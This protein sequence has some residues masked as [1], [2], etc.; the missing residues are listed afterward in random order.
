MAMYSPDSTEKPLLTFINS[1]VTGVLYRK[2]H[3]KVTTVPKTL[4]QSKDQEKNLIV[5]SNR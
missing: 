4:S 1:T 2:M 3:P 5:E